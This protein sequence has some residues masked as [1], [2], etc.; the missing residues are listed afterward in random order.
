MLGMAPRWD[1]LLFMMV[2]VDMSQAGRGQ[3]DLGLEVKQDCIPQ[4]LP[5]K[6]PLSSQAG[7]FQNSAIY[8]ETTAQT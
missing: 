4:Y 5:F 6:D 2:G 8:W 7:G 3:K 1:Q